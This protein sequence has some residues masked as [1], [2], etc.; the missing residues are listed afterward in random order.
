LVRGSA[1]LTHLFTNANPVVTPFC[2]ADFAGHHV[3]FQCPVEQ[4]SMITWQYPGFFLILTITEHM[5]DIGILFLAL[6]MFCSIGRWKWACH[7][8]LF[9]WSF[10]SKITQYKTHQRCHKDTICCPTQVPV[11]CWGPPDAQL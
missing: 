5:T 1:L 4:T 6:C 8:N 7:C 2:L 10:A 9:R 3:N 11:D